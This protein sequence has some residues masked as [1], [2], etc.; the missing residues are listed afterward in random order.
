MNWS[1][2]HLTCPSCRKI[3]IHIITQNKIEILISVAKMRE[4]F[5]NFTKEII[6]KI[7]LK[8]LLLTY[9]DYLI[10]IIRDI[11]H[12]GKKRVFERKLEKVGSDLWRQDA[13]LFTNEMI[14]KKYIKKSKVS[15]WLKSIEEKTDNLTDSFLC[16]GYGLEIIPIIVDY[17]YDVDIKLRMK[18][19]VQ[20]NNF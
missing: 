17:L 15:E 4:I 20:L 18:Y 3:N 1:D 9:E 6:N 2:M 14:M 5:S 12:F 7:E 8:I 11:K 19:Q 10:N 16:N 13:L